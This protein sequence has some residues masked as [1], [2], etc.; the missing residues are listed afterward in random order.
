MPE[1][2][3]EVVTS[4]GSAST[5]TQVEESLASPSIPGS[6]SIEVAGSQ[7]VGG[8]KDTSP[9]AQVEVA[10]AVVASPCSPSSLSPEEEVR[11]E[12]GVQED[13]VEIAVSVLAPGMEA[14][15]YSWYHTC[16]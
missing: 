5:T 3:A 1:Q 14:Q 7:E 9:G 11:K 6:V 8:S 15:A 4:P 12:T 2:V 16:Y 13:S 10:A